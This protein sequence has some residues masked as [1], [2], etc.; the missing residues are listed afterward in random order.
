MEFQSL[1]PN[2]GVAN[3]NDTVKFYTEMFGFHLTMSVPKD[4]S[5]TL[6]WAM[7]TNGKVNIMF[8]EIQNL[9]EEYPQLKSRST[10]ATLTFYVK[11]K[12]ISELYNKV[13]DTEYL[14]TEMH[15]TFY[16]ADEFA[17]FDNNGYVLTITEGE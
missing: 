7:M 14:T 10:T 15:K 6:Q 9:L 17:V 13:K 16:G 4:E 8:Q 12:N 5:G 3:V 11:M 1:S 2:I